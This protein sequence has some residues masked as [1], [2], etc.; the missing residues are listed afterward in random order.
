MQNTSIL[1]LQDISK[2]FRGL[3]AVSKVSVVLHPGE[4]VGLIGPNGA[5]KTTLFNVVSG[6][7]TPD[8]GSVTFMGKAILGMRPHKICK[9]GVTRTFQ[10]VKP[11]SHLSILQNVAVG[12]F[13][14]ASDFEEAE[15]E[16]WKILEFV[17]LEK[18]ALGQ[19]SDTTMPDRKRLELAR[20]IAS[21]PKLILLDEVMAGLNP[22]EQTQIINLVREVRDSGVTIFIIEHSMRVIMG[23]CDRIAVI[24]H[25]RRISE[26]TPSEICADKKVIEAYLGEGNAFVKA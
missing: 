25:G 19:A 21:K 15:E 14:W 12:C 22:T 23:L 4:I 16:A 20:A 11:F 18:K 26:G 9:M 8:S 1:E 6:F 17:G 10:I 2:S 24:H 5:G 3:K 7:L 13:N